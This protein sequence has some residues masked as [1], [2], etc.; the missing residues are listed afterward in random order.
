MGCL[1]E[2][3]SSTEEAFIASQKVFFVATA[4]LSGDQYINVSPKAPGT[5][6]VVLGPNKVAY[7]DLTGSGAEA[8]AN[9]QENGRMTI[10][11]VNIENGPPKILRLYGSASVIASRKVDKSLLKKFPSSITDSPGFR[12]VFVLNVDRVTTSC[13]YSMP[14]LKFEKYRS[15]LNEWYNKKGRDG[16]DGYVL[17]KNSFSIN[18]LESHCSVDGGIHVDRSRVKP[19]ER[20]GYVLGVLD[21]DEEDSK[22]RILLSRLGCKQYAKTLERLVKRNLALS[23]VAIFAVGVGVGIKATT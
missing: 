9:V 22:G 12:T 14:V 8:C 21:D 4:P 17:E 23:C 10:M 1:K 6:L 3:I 5:S 20:D 13:G 18:G 15:A 11:F 2:C 7:A 16:L 19:V